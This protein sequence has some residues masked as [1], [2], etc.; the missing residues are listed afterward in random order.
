M[1]ILE[2]EEMDALPKDHLTVGKVSVMLGI[3]CH[4]FYR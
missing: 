3:S 2:Q 4:A 1:E